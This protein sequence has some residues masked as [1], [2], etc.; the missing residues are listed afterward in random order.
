M[1]APS[2]VTPESFESLREFVQRVLTTDLDYSDD[3]TPADA[4]R[5][6]PARDPSA[7]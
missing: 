2:S 3:C 4:S 7:Q 1:V 5:N 6:A